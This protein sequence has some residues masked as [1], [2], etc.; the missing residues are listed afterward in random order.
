VNWQH[1][2]AFLW[3]RWRL[4]VN[5]FKRGG[6]ANAVIY[7]IAAAAA[8]VAGVTLFLVFLLVGALGLAKVQPVILMGVW[9]GLVIAFLF[10]WSISVI[11][12]LQRSEALSLEKFLHLPVSLTSAFLINYVSSLMNLILL[13]F[14]PAMLGL[15]LGLVV[16]RGPGMLLL[17]PV[18]AAFLLMITALTYQFQGWLAALMT[19][20]RRRRTVI[21]VVTMVFVLIFQIPNLVN[22][23]QP[24]KNDQREELRT[25]QQQELA[26]LDRD[27]TAGQITPEQF[28]Q[29]HQEITQRHQAQE[30]ELDRQTLGQVERTTRL[31]NLVLPPG[32]L[33][34]GAMAAAEGNALP[35]VLGTLGFGLM[36]AFSLWRAYRTTL[37]LYKGEFTAGQRR[38]AP[39]PVGTVKAPANLLERDL[40]WVSEHAA[41]VALGGFRSLLRAPEAKMLLL[42]PVLL[43]LI[44]GSLFLA[45]HFDL[46]EMVR[47]L[48]AFGATNMVLFTMVGLIGNQFG[49]DRG[50]FRVFVLC[51]APRRDVL[52]GKNLSFAPVALGLALVMVVLVEI[53]QPM[54]FDH[55]L[56]VLP[57][58]VSMYLLYCLLANLLSIL[59]PMAIAPGSLKPA[60]AKLVPVLLQLVF[61]FAMPVIMAPTLLPLLLEFTFGSATGATWVP[62]YLILSL[63]VCVGIVFF[64]RLAL[65]WEGTL[66]QA[67]EQKILEAVTTNAE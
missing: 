43:V 22:I 5:Q 27:W 44:F 59:G 16:G 65:G 60:N 66:L 31:L 56:A 36:G 23:M 15:A 48:I 35:P 10:A 1:L 25:Q 9:D 2:R 32:W 46:P 42:T 6:T 4:R 37:R 57:Q 20:P 17:L 34:L 26:E 19:N 55:F 53:I 67:R 40:P 51:P 49:F 41:V 12:E 11:V 21:V 38:A 45:H 18:L 50:G 14:L 61:V 39:K 58:M 24:W 28:Q 7:A 8:A 52:L 30:E 54:R 62:V 33:P 3:L 64:Y 47:P 63:G 29:R 13:I